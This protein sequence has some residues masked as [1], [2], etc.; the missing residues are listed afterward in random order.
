MDPGGSC[1]TCVR[2]QNALHRC[3]RVSWT[4]CVLSIQITV[5]P[6]LRLRC[7][8][9][10]FSILVQIDRGPDCQ[11]LR[12][13]A[14]LPHVCKLGIYHHAPKVYTGD[15]NHTKIYS[16]L[17]LMLFLLPLFRFVSERAS[18]STCIL[19]ELVKCFISSEFGFSVNAL[20]CKLFLS[21][22][23]RM[24]LQST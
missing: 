6:L 10:T 22:A 17:I 16:S 7:V 11:V 13:S 2:D 1:W 4:G 15:L 12:F 9:P 24:A 21:T 5:K 19:R 23:D 3:E 18:G 20:L 8:M 14:D